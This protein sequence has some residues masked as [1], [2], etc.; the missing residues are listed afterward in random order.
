GASSLPRRLDATGLLE[1]FTFWSVVPPQTAFEGIEELRPGYV[2]TVSA[3]GSAEHAFWQP[4]FPMAGRGGFRGPLEEAA[5]R[6]RSAL[7]EAVRRRLL[8]ADVPVGS[9]LSGG[10]DSSLV[11]ALASRASHARLRT[12]S[13]RF[14]D[15]QYD[16]TP[17]QRAA[18]SLIGSEHRE[19][20]V[21]RRDI[22]HALPGAV[23]H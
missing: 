15:A 13:I 17:Y 1:T 2:R 10:I 19:L 3:R 4:R 11:A 6:V 12:F 18:V 9:Y 8:H 23:R 5:E 14:E 16:E 22:A 20:L 21:T 7:D